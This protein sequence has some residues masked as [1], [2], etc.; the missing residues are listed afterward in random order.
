[1][2]Q[3]LPTR[4]AGAPPG[5]GRTTATRPRLP[6]PLILGALVVLAVLWF[7][8]HHENRYEKLAADVTKAIAANDMRPVEKEFNAIRRP[9]LHDRGKV[10]RLSDFV[11][12]YGGFK[13]V[14][15]DTP[16]GSKDG[17]HH[18]IAHFDKGE[19]S[20]DMTL[21][22]EGKLADFHVRPIESK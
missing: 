17:F 8:L 16:S 1:M 2:K 19:R 20:E 3:A 9:Q 12:A 7:V 5:P 13:G 6:V 18:F 4:L 14:K 15:E 11:N 22:A 10:G 21:D